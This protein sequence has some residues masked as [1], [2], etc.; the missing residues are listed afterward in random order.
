[1]SYRGLSDLHF[2]PPKQTVNALYYV[3]EILEGTCL[4]TLKRRRI[5][6]PVYSRKLVLK[7]SE[8]HFMQDGAPTHRAIV[9]QEWCKKHFSSFWIKDEWPGN[10]PDLN[11]IENIWGILKQSIDEMKQPNNLE[12]LKNQLEIAWKYPTPMAR[13]Y[14]GR[15]ARKDQ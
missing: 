11:P 13:E 7:R 2:I 9:T 4:N 15:H 6:G 3:S 10:S 5:N 8:A 1:M 12:Q 14:C